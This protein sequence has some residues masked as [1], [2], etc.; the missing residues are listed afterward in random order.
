MPDL[1]AAAGEVGDLHAGADAAADALGAVGQPPH[2]TGDGAG[3][4]Q[5]QHDHDRGRNAADLQNR[6]PLVRHHLVDVIALRR[7][8]QCAM[9]GAEALHR[10]GH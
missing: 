1:V 9:H 10:H 3:E 5:R 2:R 7:Q 8:Q 4:Q 6:E